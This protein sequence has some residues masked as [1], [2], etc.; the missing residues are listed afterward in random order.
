MHLIVPT[1]LAAHV[2]TEETLLELW[3]LLSDILLSFSLLAK[4]TYLSNNIYDF[5]TE[6]FYQCT[7]L[8]K[9]FLKCHMKMCAIMRCSFRD[10]LKTYYIFFSKKYYGLLIIVK[11]NLNMAILDTVWIKWRLR[12]CGF[13]MLVYSIYFTS[14]KYLKNTISFAQNVLLLCC[15]QLGNER[16]QMK[17]KESLQWDLCSAG[18]SKSFCCNVKGCSGLSFKLWMVCADIFSSWHLLLPSLLSTVSLK[19]Y[20]LLQLA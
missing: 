12:C 15:S 6:P 1:P 7:F 2:W 20:S 9:Y 4:S 18:Q 5:A 11:M 14:S 19:R 8:W 13:K 16:V 17:K 3:A 10:C